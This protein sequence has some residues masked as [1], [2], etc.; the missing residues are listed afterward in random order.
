[1]DDLTVSNADHPHSRAQA[2]CDDPVSGSLGHSPPSWFT[3]GEPGQL[4]Q[5]DNSRR[6]G[7]CFLLHWSQI[8]PYTIIVLV[9][10]KRPNISHHYR[11]QC[12]HSPTKLQMPSCTIMKVKDVLKDQFTANCISNAW[13]ETLLKGVYPTRL[14]LLIGSIWKYWAR[15]IEPLLLIWGNESTTPKQA[16][17]MGKHVS[18]GCFS[19]LDPQARGLIQGTASLRSVIHPSLNLR[20]GTTLPWVGD[21]V[22]AQRSMTNTRSSQGLPAKQGANLDSTIWS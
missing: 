10:P 5:R 11:K 4:Y 22:L 7:A 17:L 3:A 14:T 6:G 9:S 15:V 12:I 20:E 18:E 13:R 8:E 16:R 1:M 19:C 21:E 2:S